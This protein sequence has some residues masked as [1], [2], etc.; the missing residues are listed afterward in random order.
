MAEK[1]IEGLTGAIGQELTRLG[2]SRSTR[3]RTQRDAVSDV[4]WASDSA[5]INGTSV[6]FDTAGIIKFPAAVAP[7]QKIRILS[8]L[9]QLPSVSEDIALRNSDF[10]ITLAGSALL[11]TAESGVSIEIWDPATLPVDIDVETTHGWEDNGYFVMGDELFR[12]TGKTTNSLQNI[13]HFNGE[14]WVY[15]VPKV[16]ESGTEVVDYTRIYSGVDKMRRSFL[17]DFAGG[18]DLDIVGQNLGVPRPPQLADDEKYRKLI[19]ALAYVPRG[20]IWVMEL[21]LRAIF[22]EGNF[23][24]FEDM[25]EALKA[26]VS[27]PLPTSATRIGKINHPGFVFIRAAGT[28]ETEVGKAFI[29]EYERRPLDSATQVTVARATPIAIGGVRLAGEGNF[30]RHVISGDS[31]GLTV[32]IVESPAGSFAYMTLTFSAGIFPA[33]RPRKGDLFYVTKPKTSAGFVAPVLKRAAADEI[34]LGAVPGS[35][36]THAQTLPSTDFEWRIIRENTNAR[37][38]LPSADVHEEYISDPGRQIWNWRSASTE[39]SRADLQTAPATDGDYTRIQN[40]GDPYAYYEQG[41][42]VL[43]TSDAT[44]EA[45]V[46]ADNTISATANEADQVGMRLNDGQKA[47]SVGVVLDTPDHRWGFTSAGSLIDPTGGYVASTGEWVH[48]KIEKDG[49]NAVRLYANGQLVQVADY[50][51]FGGAGTTEPTRQIGALDAVSGAHLYVKEIDWAAQTNRDY[52]NFHVTEGGTGA[53]D[54]ITGIAPLNAFANAVSGDLVRVTTLA[55]SAQNSADGDPR[56]LW[57]IDNVVDADNVDVVGLP[58]GKVAFTSS[59]DHMAIT[60]DPDDEFMFPDNLGHKLTITEGGN[61]GTY[62]IDEIHDVPSLS[63]PSGNTVGE[64]APGQV[65]P[66]PI[67]NLRQSARAIVTPI[68]DPNFSVLE[69]EARWRLDP[70][71][72]TDGSGAVI[73]EVVAQG[74]VAGSVLTLPQTFPITPSGDHPLVEVGYSSVLSAQV[75]DERARNTSNSHYPFYLGDPANL[76][77]VRNFLQEVVTA[78]GI[79][80]GRFMR[81]DAGPHII[82]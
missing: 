7:G 20:T 22:G 78:A 28:P 57:K 36:A 16:F 76:G 21:V 43:P 12:Y 58:R 81:D 73:F 32:A 17:V 68:T 42:R 59:N 31:S 24:I 6:T 48:L 1:N 3:L 65:D 35:P 82:E 60:T 52:W 9:I 63:S 79:H 29:E 26:S 13:E 47:L 62:T 18:V 39:A 11:S 75:L 34:W 38:Y 30:D 19:K 40:F 56:G 53:T 50:S 49:D 15:T 25:T 54:R 45:V 71:F 2:G 4:F 69:P 55:T 61:A 74:S 70:T 80:I 44:F 46:R 67:E 51:A 5:T 64:Y 14:V 66:S 77:W 72:V 27:M 41:A 23:E 37:W 8:P 10:S 33:D